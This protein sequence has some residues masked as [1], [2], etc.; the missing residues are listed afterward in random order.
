LSDTII[1]YKI[2]IVSLRNHG[3]I[4]THIQLFR[5]HRIQKDMETGQGN[6]G[7]CQWKSSDQ[8][9][10]LCLKGRQRS[11][12]HDEEGHLGGKKLTKQLST[13]FY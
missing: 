11:G 5:R 10:C 9:T 4:T 8:E 3:K 1:L 12:Y 6:E 2:E 13:L 7:T